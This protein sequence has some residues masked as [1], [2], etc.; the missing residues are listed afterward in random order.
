MKFY[1]GQKVIYC[2]DAFAKNYIAEI[3]NTPPSNLWFFSYTIKILSTARTGEI[4]IVPRK[5]LKEM[6]F[7]HYIQESLEENK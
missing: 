6:D 4:A 1:K 7:E 3:V 2:S 5:N